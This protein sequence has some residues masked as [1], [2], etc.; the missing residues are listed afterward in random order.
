MSDHFFHVEFINVFFHKG[1]Y[2]FKENFTNHFLAN[3]NRYNYLWNCGYF[4]D[5]DVSIEI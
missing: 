4:F 5:D 2:A 3:L 1:A